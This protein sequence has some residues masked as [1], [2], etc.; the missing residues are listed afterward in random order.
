MAGRLTVW[1]YVVVAVM[2]S[3]SASIGVVFAYRR[4]KHNNTQV[5]VT[6]TG[7]VRTFES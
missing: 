6:S 7:H 1:D 4:R 5:R 3:V 2:L